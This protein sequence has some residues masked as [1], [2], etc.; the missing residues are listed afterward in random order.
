MLDYEK[1]HADENARSF[2]YF[3][4][5]RKEDRGTVIYHV[6]SGEA[7]VVAPAPGDYANYYANHLLL[8]LERNRGNLPDFGCLMWY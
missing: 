2:D 8:E 7:D 3:V 1:T 5:G 6:A 4:E